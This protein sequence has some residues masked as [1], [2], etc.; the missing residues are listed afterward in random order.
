MYVCVVNSFS[1]SATD[2]LQQL[3]RST[4][5]E[6]EKMEVSNTSRDSLGTLFHIYIII[7]AVLPLKLGNRDTVL[8]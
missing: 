5:N 7:V 1:E 4:S 3:S 8:P 2:S 6:R